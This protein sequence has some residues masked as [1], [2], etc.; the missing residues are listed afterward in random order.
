MNGRE[1]DPEL[2]SQT[3]SQVRLWR[4]N[5]EATNDARAKLNGLI[6]EMKKTGHSYSQIREVTG[7]GIST[8]QFILAKAGMYTPGAAEE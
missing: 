8:I 2:V 7:F 1:P 5:Q 4:A 3:R 6:I